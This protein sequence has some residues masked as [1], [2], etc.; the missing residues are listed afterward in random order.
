METT[1]PH[2]G[3]SLC[4]PD[5]LKDTVPKQPMSATLRERLRKTRRSFNGAFS[6]AKRLKVD[7]EENESSSDCPN[8]NLPS[9]KD[10]E[11]NATKTDVNFVSVEDVHR[12]SSGTSSAAS[13]PINS[14]DS[15]HHQEMLQEKK[16]LLKKVKEKEDTLRRLK[17]AKL[18][19]SKNNLS[20]LQSL[21]EKWRKG[22]QLLLYE[23][24]AALSAENNKV[25]LTQ[26]IE[27]C[28]LDEKLL[29]YSRTEEDFTDQ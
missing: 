17:M 13:S 23:L 27:S 21:I 28:G 2:P 10:S 15:F 18:Y 4:S 20:E 29:H 25:T 11:L 8:N 14:K 22:S 6:V 1:S 5:S 9:H 26:L 7:C 12:L 3:S 24:Q 19:R 16:L